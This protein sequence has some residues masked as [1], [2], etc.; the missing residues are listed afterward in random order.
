MKAFLV[1]TAFLCVV[2]NSP[3]SSAE[4]AALAPLY[5]AVTPQSFAVQEPASL[6]P[7]YEACDESVAEVRCDCNGQGDCVCGDECEC[8]AKFQR[9]VAKPKATMK[10]SAE[11]LAR[12]QLPADDPPPRPELKEPERPSNR[13]TQ[14]QIV[15]A[16]GIDD[17]SDQIAA[18]LVPR[19][20][21]FG[22]S[23]N[24]HIRKRI[25]SE[26]PE[27]LT[28][29]RVKKLPE[30]I[31]TYDGREIERKSGEFPGWKYLTDR[32]IAVS[33][34]K[35][36][37]PAQQATSAVEPRRGYPIRSGL[38]THSGRGSGHLQSG[39]LQSGRHANKFP[40]EWLSSLTH[41][42][43]ESLHSDDHEG[44]VK[45]DYIPR[46]TATAQRREP[47]YGQKTICD[48]NGC[49]TVQVLIGYR[50]A[51]GAD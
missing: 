4:L 35:G 41:A 42:E 22:T 45:W 24:A 50:M 29:L 51:N 38:S 33:T 34:G 12:M 26:N 25:V 5:E 14:W 10:L 36:E 43:R 23:P 21:E 1:A 19:G 27:V 44:R 17:G 49:R 15:T 40:Q 31:L 8:Q 30:Y 48:G 7:L 39:H 47:I 18:V 11:A 28:Q 20:W 3:C 46:Y 37:Q 9:S 16:P 6:A 13:R 32:W 2:A